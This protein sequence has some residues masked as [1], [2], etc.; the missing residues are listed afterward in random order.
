MSSAGHARP[1]PSCPQSSR[2]WHSQHSF[3]FSQDNIPTASALQELGSKKGPVSQG[4]A[5]CFSSTAFP[6]RVDSRAWIPCS[7][8]RPDLAEGFSRLGLREHSAHIYI[9]PEPLEHCQTESET[10]GSGTIPSFTQQHQR[11]TLRALLTPPQP[12]AGA[13]RKSTNMTCQRPTAVRGPS[14]LPG[15]QPAVRATVSAPITVPLAQGCPL[16]LAND[17]L[18]VLA[19]K[20]PPHKPSS[21]PQA[22]PGLTRRSPP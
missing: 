15:L 10:S 11:A 7:S 9:L 16:S 8:P 2:S 20:P 6:Q 4:F 1:A 21:S 22:R 3:I 19:S 5:F 18:Q 13:R 12:A 14:F 17:T